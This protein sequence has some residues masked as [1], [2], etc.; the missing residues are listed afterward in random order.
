MKK[1][2]TLFNRSG[3]TWADLANSQWIP[4]N[5]NSGLPV[6]DIF[7]FIVYYYEAPPNKPQA[8]RN[9]V[10]LAQRWSRSGSGLL[11]GFEF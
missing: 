8:T 5:P 10:D 6:K 9:A 3:S 1:V 4:P 11:P 7:Q 2:L